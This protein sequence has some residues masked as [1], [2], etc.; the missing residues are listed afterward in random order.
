MKINKINICKWGRTPDRSVR[1][2]IEVC[3]Y[4]HVIYRWIRHFVLI[5]SHVDKRSKNQCFG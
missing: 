4:G 2:K 5:Q 1:M 3:K